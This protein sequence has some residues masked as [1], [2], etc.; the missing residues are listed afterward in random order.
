M[1]NV[2]A[3][4]ALAIISVTTTFAQDSVSVDQKIKRDTIKLKHWKKKNGFALNLNEVAFS[5]WNAGG[6]NS[7]STLGK[8]TF[9]R[10]YQKGNLQW[11]NEMILRY[12]LN[13]QEGQKIRKTDDAIILNSTFGYRKDSLSNWYYSA[14]LNFN[15]QFSNG[16]NYPDRDNPISR[17]MAPGYLFAGFGVEYSPDDEDLTIYLSPTTNKSTF[18]LDQDL[19]NDGAFGVDGAR[20]DMNG[21]MI[22]KGKQ[23]MGEFG[24]LISS[25][26]Q[27]E[28]YKNMLLNNRISFYT[29]YINSFG[30]IDIDWELNIDLKVN[31]FVKAN[32]GTHIKYDNDVKFNEFTD[33]TTGESY[34]YGARIQLKQLLG[35]GVIYNF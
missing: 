2:L 23:Y 14:K 35:V 6:D 29:D 18:V 27:K 25:T 13:L 16:Y 19:A 8:A 24:V 17:F 15:T 21:N 31:D 20:Y 11:N 10:K 26:W 22:K 30:N 33:E 4:I 1:K 12:G 3:C 28:V 32:I 34:T 9:T 7:V 5:N